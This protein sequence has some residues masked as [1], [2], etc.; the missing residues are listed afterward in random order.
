MGELGEDAEAWHLPAL[1]FLLLLG[2][3]VPLTNSVSILLWVG[4]AH[5]LTLVRFSFTSCW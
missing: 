5:D 4:N 1:V 3:L 2:E